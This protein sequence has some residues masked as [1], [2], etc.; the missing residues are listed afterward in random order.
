MVLQVESLQDLIEKRDEED[1]TM[2]R[3]IQITN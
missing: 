1:E 2:P 3:G